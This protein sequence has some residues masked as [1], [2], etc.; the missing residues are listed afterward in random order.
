MKADA[1]INP[2]PGADVTRWSLACATG[3]HDSCKGYRFNP[4]PNATADKVT[5]S[6]ECTHPD[7]ATGHGAPAR[8]GR[9]PKAAREAAETSG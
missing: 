4:D 2:P 7:H 9:P 6:C 5:L 1:P 8:R 3:D